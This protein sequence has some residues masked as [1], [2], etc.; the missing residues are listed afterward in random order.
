[1][2][3]DNIP[4]PYPYI[5]YPVNPQPTPPWVIPG[6][7]LGTPPYWA[8]IPQGSTGV[9][10]TSAGTLSPGVTGYPAG[11]PAPMSFGS[12]L[13]PQATGQ[14]Y[15]LTTGMAP[16]S[17]ADQNFEMAPGSP[18]PKG[19]AYTQG[20]L[21]TQ[22]GQTLRIEFLIG[23]NSLQDRRGTLL[24]VG[25]DYIIIRESDTDDQLLCDIYSIKFVTVYK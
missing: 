16:T 4:N 22:I 21:R 14:T 17:P 19:I 5:N 9:P 15:P 10:G 7:A 13:P 20:W 8:P 12:N 3:Q 23:T 1:M 24:E 25:I 18:V 6:T 11:T 2:I